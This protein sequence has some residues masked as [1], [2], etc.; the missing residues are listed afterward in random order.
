MCITHW[1]PWPGDGY[2]G[3][4]PARVC[5]DKGDERVPAGIPLRR[6]PKA[7]EFVCCD[8][9]RIADYFCQLEVHSLFSN[10][11]IWL[12]TEIKRE[13]KR[14]EYAEWHDLDLHVALLFVW[15]SFCCHMSLNDDGESNVLEGIQNLELLTDLRETSW[16]KVEVVLDWLDC[17][18]CHVWVVVCM[19]WVLLL[20][21]WNL[22]LWVIS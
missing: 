2:G 19:S 12:S 5:P 6:L 9:E 15:G 1:S 20:E 8:D 21:I 22:M 18:T 4:C 10:K 13:F 7:P 11:T 3:I 14:G 17:G 16:R